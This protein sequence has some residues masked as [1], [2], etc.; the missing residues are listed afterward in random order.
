MSIGHRIIGE[1]L[2]VL[3]WGRAIL[4]QLAH[5][6]VAA[7]VDEHSTFRE[8]PIA[9]ARRLHATIQTMLALTFGTRA[10]VTGAAARINRIHDRVHGT[11]GEATG[12]FPVGTPYSAHDP[13]LLTWVQLTLVDS[14]PIAYEAFIGP[15]SA[16]ERDAWC[17]EARGIAP[18]LGFPPERLPGTLAGVRSAVTE[19]LVSGEL[20]VGGVAR[21]LAASVLHPP[22]ERLTYPW[23]RLNRLATI[24]LLPPVLREQYGLTWTSADA[25]ALDR[26]SRVTRAAA[27]RTPAVLR[28]WRAARRATQPSAM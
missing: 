17:L 24:G 4:M 25:R 27:A 8:S 12:R 23:S 7:G 6:L 10:D 2:V 5:P 3:G 1:R 9:P 16:G 28:R 14:L 26:W 15:L 18:L 13:D 22:F 19:R 11:L 20:E 21:R